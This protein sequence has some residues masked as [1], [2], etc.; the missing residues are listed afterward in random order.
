M[1]LVTQQGSV[2]DRLRN[3]FRVTGR[4]PAG[5]DETVVPVANIQYLGEP[6]WR[7][8]DA[9]FAVHGNVAAVAAVNSHIG[10]VMPGRTNGVAVVQEVS[11]RNNTAATA[12]YSL[13][14]VAGAEAFA[15]FAV[16]T[17]SLNTERPDPFNSG[18][19]FGTTVPNLAGFTT[20]PLAGF[21]LARLAALPGSNAIFTCR[22]SLRGRYG[23]NL[24]ASQGLF[25]ANRTVNVAITAGFRG[26]FFP[27]A[28]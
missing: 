6:P 7:T 11:V 27:A 15:D 10:V 3:F 12:E 14:F 21:E 13:L 22:V 2:A 8:Q 9:D 25:V 26:T 17:P 18:S 1:P 24:A 4:I 19:A 20:L 23:T 16:I 28:L 5:L